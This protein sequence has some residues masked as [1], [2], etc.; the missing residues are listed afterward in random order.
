MQ[1]GIFIARACL[2]P[3]SSAARR[4]ARDPA[5][6]LGTQA[7]G[8]WLPDAARIALLPPGKVSHGHNC[9]SNALGRAIRHGIASV[10]HVFAKRSASVKGR[11]RQKLRLRA[12]WP[13]GFARAQAPNA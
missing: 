6:A 3:R 13:E 4:V 1:A 11:L 12:G 7:R 2:V 10:K 9:A 8:L 5:S